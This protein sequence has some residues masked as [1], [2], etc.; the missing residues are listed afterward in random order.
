[1][2]APAVSVL[3]P[4]VS[5]LEFL[6]R[7]VDSVLAQSFGDLE[8]VV[9]LDGPSGPIAAFVEGHPDPRV[10]LVRHDSRRGVAAARNTGIA[11][12]SGE[13]VA[14]LDDDD[15]WLPTKLERQ[16]EAVERGAEV[17]HTL[18]YIA[19]AEGNVYE[20]PTQAG[21][22]LFREA[23]AAGYPYD[24]LVRRS[25]FVINTFLVRRRCVEEVGGFDESLPG[26]DDVDYVH[27]LWRRYPLTLVDEPLVKYC[28]HG[29]NQVYSKDPAVSIRLAAKELDWLAEANVPKQQEIRA[30]HHLQVAQASWIGGRY[31]TAVPAALRARRLD[32]SVI[33]GK[34]LV[35][36]LA[37]ALLP[38]TLVDSVRQ[39]TRHRRLPAEP[40]PW[41]E[42]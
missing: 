34:T 15:V 16:M 9:I 36:Y 38:A 3:I 23:A 6:R 33:S 21:F 11:A 5:R 35:K 17:V 24:L 39:R 18:V 1:V 27:R 40:Y 41:V 7:A 12:S 42:L 30:Y 8:A 4:T 31:R 10:R 19:D 20:E 28:F 14:F 37:A 32:P 29:R 13:N 2:A 22:R 25:S 26:V